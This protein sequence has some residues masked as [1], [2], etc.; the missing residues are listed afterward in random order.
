MT[1]PNRYNQYNGMQTTSTPPRQSANAII[2]HPNQFTSRS[3]VPQPY[4][5]MPYRSS[6]G[7][8]ARGRYVEDNLPPPPPQYL[9][10]SMMTL[11]GDCGVPE[12]ML[13]KRYPG[14]SIAGVRGRETSLSYND[15]VNLDET[16]INPTLGD[17]DAFYRR[18]NNIPPMAYSSG[19]MTM[20]HFN[21]PGQ[22]Y[23]DPSPSTV[24]DEYSPAFRGCNAVDRQ[25]PHVLCHPGQGTSSNYGIHHSHCISPSKT[26][27]SKPVETDIH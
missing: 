23:N 16:D 15:L 3:H 17:D 26:D 7:Q 8:V 19:L 24:A 6:I 18:P 12:M 2:T 27:Y 14:R 22:S 4:N 10:Q 1:F 13:T 25:K 5:T 9:G 20:P 21:P 11:R